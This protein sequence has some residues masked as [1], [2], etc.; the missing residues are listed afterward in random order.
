MILV[1]IARVWVLVSL[2]V[3]LAACSASSR[4]QDPAGV[5]F[6]SDQFHLGVTLPPGWAAAE[7]PKQLTEPFVGLVAFTSWGQAGFWAPALMEGDSGTYWPL[8]TLA[9]VPDGGAYVILIYRSGRPSM[10]EYGPEH[11]S[12]GMADL[13]EQRDCRQ[14]E[15]VNWVTFEK[16]G[17]LFRLEVYCRPDA[18]DATAEAVDDLIGGWRF[19]PALPGDPGWASAQARS[20][21]PAAVHPEWFPVLAGEFVGK[22]PLHASI[23]RGIATR[24]THA[25]IEGGTV[26]VTFL[27]RRDDLPSGQA[28][29]QLAGGNECPPDRCHWWRFKARASGDVTLAEEG[30]AAL[31]SLPIK[32]TWSSY[33]DPVLGFAAVYPSDWEVEVPKSY[34]DERGRWWTMIE[35]QSALH[36]YG[37]QACDEYGINVQVGPRLGQTLTETVESMLSPVAPAYRKGI[38]RRCCLS[39]GG[40]PA[41]ELLGFPPT[42]WGNREIILLREGREYRLNFYPQQSLAGSTPADAEARAAFNAFLRTFAFVPITWT[43]LPPTPTLAPVPTPTPIRLAPTTAESQKLNPKRPDRRHPGG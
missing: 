12:E 9:Q 13:W 35:V 28:A 32:G 21:L 16:W 2:G 18:S 19:D 36:G 11:T 8:T 17:R 38:E 15:G 33:S 20:L 29:G 10:D 39:V 30:G 37:E 1:K 6:R 5:P 7:G 14:A 42:R 25:E 31:S 24:M 23:T 22:G 43:P 40:E 41:V 34:I 27:L 4:G 26:F 3:L